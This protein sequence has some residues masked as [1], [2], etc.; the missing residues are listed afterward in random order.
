MRSES[1][2]RKPEAP[3][4]SPSWERNQSASLGQHP[5]EQRGRRQQL[6]FAEAFG[7]FSALALLMAAIVELLV[8]SLF[9]HDS[10]MSQI[11]GTREKDKG[12]TARS[13]FL[14]RFC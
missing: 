4:L 1:G 8:G 3:A 11:P 2:A 7:R 12:K 10:I 14:L 5:E 6:S 13:L 9:L